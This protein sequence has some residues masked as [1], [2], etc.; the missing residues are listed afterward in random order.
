MKIYRFII[1]LTI[2]GLI[3]GCE[4]KSHVKR[5]SNN[6]IKKKIVIPSGSSI[7][8]E[9]SRYGLE[10]KQI[11]DLITA[12]G[13]DIDVQSIPPGAVFFIKIDPESKE[14]TE[15]LYQEDIV[16]YH[17]LSLIDGKYNYDLIEKETEKRHRIVEGLVYNSLDEALAEKG[18]DS[19]LKQEINSALSSKINFRSAAKKGDYF[20]ALIEENY[21]GAVKLKG[22]RLLYVS[23]R[24]KSA[25]NCEG[26]YYAESDKKSAYNGMYLENGLA[27]LS[28]TLRMPLDRIQITSSFGVRL[29][30]ISR[31]WKMHNGIDYRATTGTPVFAISSGTVIRSSWYGGYGKTV[32]IRHNDGY[33]SQYAHLHSMQVRQ[34]NAV[35]GGQ[36]IGSVGSTGYSTGAHLHF[37]IRD[38]RS[39]LNPR[40]FK[41]ISA[42]KLSAAR[43][44][45][46]KEQ[47]SM[48][49]N[50][51]RKA[52][53]PETSPMEMTILEKYRRSQK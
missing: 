23:Y 17:R 21:Y 4:S 30:P 43:M 27:M 10:A 37:G 41:M 46:F 33:I 32:E 22:S 47:I 6:L 26:Y 13:E 44:L 53:N 40:N 18:V 28:A 12:L 14:V 7:Y 25:G 48:I 11:I 9:F 42:T 16:T 45:Q 15:L 5:E 1:I 19:R 8:N 31:T 20:K 29:H 50:L 35:R 39:W 52:E 34:G 2:I 38:K 3:F 51:I 36:I 24:G 49:K